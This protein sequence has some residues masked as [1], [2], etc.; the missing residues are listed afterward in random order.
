MAVGDLA[1]LLYSISMMLTALPGGHSK[2]VEVHMREQKNKERGSFS[3]KN[4]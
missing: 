4:A 2:Y 3:A 1:I